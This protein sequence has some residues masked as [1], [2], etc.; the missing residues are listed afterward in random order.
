MWVVNKCGEPFAVEVG[1]LFP[2]K[3]GGTWPCL[4]TMTLAFSSLYIN[5]T[6]MSFRGT[7]LSAFYTLEFSDMP[8]FVR[9]VVYPHSGS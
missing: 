5:I 3:A 7:R 8:G 1:Q 6:T 4:V 9:A 2:I